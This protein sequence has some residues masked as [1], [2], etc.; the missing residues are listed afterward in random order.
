MRALATLGNV[1][2]DLIMGPTAPWPRPG[3]EVIVA[4]DEL[5]PGGAAG[6]AALAWAGLG[7]PFTIAS[8]VGR[9]AFGQWLSDA[10]R[11]HS[12][13]WTPSP[14]GTTISVGLTHPGDERTFFTTLGH[15]PA[16]SWDDARAQLDGLEGG[17]LLVCGTFLTDR[18]TAEYP[19]LFAWAEARG[20]D[21]ALDPGWPV[22]GWTEGERGRAAA[23][24]AST[25][26]LLVNEVEAMALSGADRIPDAL[27]ALAALMPSGA[28]VVV[29]AGPEGAHGRR[30]GESAHALAPAV[31]V[32]DTI[33][34]GDVFN[35]GYLLAVAEGA[36]LAGALE[37]GVAL[38]SR[39]IATSPRTYERPAASR[40]PA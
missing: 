12:G 11:P 5:R 25:R 36:P 31:R 32:I 6:N 3:T 19:A 9:D 10:F 13:N 34:A 2:V 27:R 22:T 1:N 38:A 4:H 29:K 35:A 40:V 28:T 8:N 18:L 39:A 14:T 16:L 26:H 37:A 23:W 21:V 33:G 24:L 7:V 20:V 15:L 17:L 30:G